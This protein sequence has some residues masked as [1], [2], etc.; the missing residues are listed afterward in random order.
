MKSIK[1]MIMII[2]LCLIPKEIEKDHWKEN[3]IERNW[4]N[5]NELLLKGTGWRTRNGKE[6]YY[7]NN[8]ASTGLKQ[9][10]GRT[11]YFD[12][13]TFEKKYGVIKKEY[14][15]IELDDKTGEWKRKK[16][17]PTYY[18]QKDE[19][20]REEIYGIGTLGGTGCA[21]TSMAMAFTS[22]KETKILPTE[23]ASYLYQNTEEYNKN[24]IGTSGR[25]IIEASTAYGI[26]Y[27]GIPTKE[28]LIEELKAG[29]IIY[30]AM[31][32]EKFTEGNWTHAIIMFRHDPE[33]NATYTY[34]PL[35]IE[36]N[37]W[38]KIDQI[39]EEQSMDPDDRTGGYSLYSLYSE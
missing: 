9:I 19:K 2:L 16:Y 15:E 3:K 31:S 23:I 17:I 26:K 10:G 8:V 35:K 13:K 5:T 12:E 32:G 6:Y 30:A 20:W 18:N 21:P 28:K 38:T 27:K 39:W 29:R 34:D 22:L 33:Q 4:N 25:G 11:Y 37:G 7:E 14:Y 24:A 1:Q 36:N